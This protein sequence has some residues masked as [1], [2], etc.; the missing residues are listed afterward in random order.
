MCNFYW[1]NFSVC[2]SQSSFGVRSCCKSVHLFVHSVSCIS[3]VLSIIIPFMSPIFVVSV[4]QMVRYR[5]SHVFVWLNHSMKWKC[6]EYQKAEMMKNTK[7]IYVRIFHWQNSRKHISKIQISCSLQNGKELATNTHPIN[8]HIHANAE[9][10]TNY[11]WCKTLWMWSLTAGSTKNKMHS[12]EKKR[13][14]EPSNLYMV[15]RESRVWCAFSFAWQQ[16]K[17]THKSPE[18]N[19]ANGNGNGNVTWLQCTWACNTHTSAPVTGIQHRPITHV[20]WHT[21]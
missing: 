12:K 19:G 1:L 15:V 4:S 18:W 16:G 17:C 6:I 2:K 9:Y 11:N 21:F 20:E 10:K 13:K 3:F 7:K 8:N 5:L 14:Q